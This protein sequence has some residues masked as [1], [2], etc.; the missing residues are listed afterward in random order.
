[1]KLVTRTLVALL[2]L[3][4]VLPALPAAGQGD[5]G[6]KQLAVELLQDGFDLP[7]F[8][9]HAG[10]ERLFVLE[11]AGVI[12]IVENGQTLPEP[13]LDIR[14]LVHADQF[15]QGL[16]GLAFHPEYETNG[17]FYVSYSPPPSGRQFILERYQ[18]SADDPNKADP[19]SGTILL[20]IYHEGINH[21]GGMLAF[22]PDGYLYVSTGDGGGAYDPLKN[23]QDLTTLLAAI[24]RLDVDGGEPYAI[25]ADNPFVG[26]DDAR[27][28]IWAWGLR[29]PWRF[30][31]DP[32][33]GDMFI[34]DVGQETWEEINHYPASA[35]GGLNF[36]WSQV[37]GFECNQFIP[38]CDPSLYVPPAVAIRNGYPNACSITGGYV[39]RGNPESSLYG[40]YLFGDFCY[41]NIWALDNNGDP[42]EYDL[43]LPTALNISSFGEDVHGEIY[44][45]DLYLGR[46]YKI[47]EQTE[48]P[49]AILTA[50]E[51]GGLP[52]G[53]ETC[54]VSLRGSNLR[55]ESRVHVNGQP[56]DT[57]MTTPTMLEF[58]IGGSDL[59]E[60]G[61]VEVTVVTPGAVPEASEPIMLSV[62][63]GMV[64]G[65]A[66]ANTWARTDQPVRNSDVNRTWIWG[67]EGLFCATGEQY[68]DA[69]GGVR[70]VQY[71]DKA[72]MEINNPDGDPDSIWYVTNGLLVVEMIT[73][74][75]QMGNTLFEPRE[76]AA[77]N[78]AGDLDDETGPTY[79]TFAGLL[80]AEPLEVGTVITQMVNRAGEVGDDP[81]LAEYGVQAARIAP[82]TGHVVAA[83]FW[84]FMNAT[85]LV[86]VDGSL[87][88]DHLFENPYY[89][90]GL[91]ISEAYWTTVRVAGTEKPV[92]VQ[93]FER[94]V[95]TYTPSNPDG[96]KVE[97]GN[98]GMHYY[99]W[100]YET[101]PDR[102]VWQ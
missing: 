3:T 77:L 74:Q 14:H 97:L 51:P 58:K 90:T 83:P 4:I 37:E 56:R 25:P 67:P 78:V 52:A 42:W 59:A 61:A 48:T 29:N 69:P 45:T 53:S 54:I 84:E 15:E 86:S 95:L 100:R 16:F 60:P 64:A 2:V 80:D 36:G 49:Q 89:A 32:V 70:T 39:Y 94:R 21:Y 13:F 79:E 19:E 82:E 11:K 63:D 41:G 75:V 92:L 43:V 46:V 102:S 22:G 71:F 57:R 27:D 31:F 81:G 76:P 35:P 44:V 17:L 12:K 7:I 30:S 8:V 62:L 18:R 66:I 24:L 34:G 23:S 87:T 93:A 38:D 26:V 40:R 5:T 28:E 85:G 91:P 20:D 96:W 99:F 101:Y 88:T 98:V 33:T 10:D 73:G 9:T 1:M 65:G 55:P 68:A 47:V 6:E 72:R 50:L